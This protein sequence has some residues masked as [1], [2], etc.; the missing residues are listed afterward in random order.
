MKTRRKKNGRKDKKPEGVEKK[1]NTTPRVLLVRSVEMARKPRNGPERNGQK[2]T[3]KRYS[4]LT[5]P[6]K[7]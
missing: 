3:F 1:K 5:A 7:N 2:Y 6:S 4:D